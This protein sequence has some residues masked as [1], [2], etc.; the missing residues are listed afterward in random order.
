[1]GASSSDCA[2]ELLNQAAYRVTSV[3]VFIE[4]TSPAGR[5]SSWSHSKRPSASF[6]L[7]PA[8][9]RE[10]PSVCT[11]CSPCIAS[12]NGRSEEKLLRCP[13]RCATACLAHTSCRN[14]ERLSAQASCGKF[15]WLAVKN[16]ATQISISIHDFLLLPTFCLQLSRISAFFGRA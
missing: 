13:Y 5:S 1:M 2:A 15:C 4:N 11:T 14:R 12:D 9:R 10:V 3:V 7:A 6:A 8:Y 16:L